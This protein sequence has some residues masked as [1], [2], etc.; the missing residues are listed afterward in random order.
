MLH[1]FSRTIVRHSRMLWSVS[2][3]ICLKKPV[4]RSEDR[5]C[6]LSPDVEGSCFWRQ[7]VLKKQSEDLKIKVSTQIH[8]LKTQVSKV[9]RL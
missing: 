3:D 9:P 1:K 4:R 8:M 5:S 6:Y 7:Q 2:F